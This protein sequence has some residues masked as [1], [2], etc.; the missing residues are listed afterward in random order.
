[1]NDYCLQSKDSDRAKILSNVIKFLKFPL[2]VLV[3]I[4]HSDLSTKPFE[5]MGL[6]ADD[7]ADPLYATISWLLSRY[8]AYAAVPCFFVISGFLLFYNVVGYDRKIY[9]GKLKKRC[10]SL[11][12]PYISWC[13]IYLFL[14]WVV[15]QKNIILSEIPNLFDNSLSPLSFIVTVF[16]KP[17]D[18]PLWFI[19]NLFAMVV[20]SP[21]LY[22]I[23]NRTKFLL[24]LSLLVLTQMV[25]SPIIESFLWFSSGIS[26]AV[27]KFDFLY[28]CYKW[29]GICLSITLLSVILDFILYPQI[30]MHMTGYFSIF[31]IMTVF[32]IGYLCVKRFPSLSNNTILNE[33]SFT[34]YAYHGFAVLIFIPLIYKIIAKW[35]GVIATYAITIV[36]IV[37]MGVAL[38]VLINSNSKIRKILCGR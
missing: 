36:L 14:Y 29:L 21:I 32:G 23:I 5:L 26:F 1:M 18:G 15:G 35:G 11:L 19:R 7:L 13:V 31:K 6:T 28:F 9:L 37:L 17:L 27:H 20:L 12:I 2:A 38:S 8:L 10:K 22:Y 4:L 3:V 16:V 33:C 24:P 30:N 25:H 34:I